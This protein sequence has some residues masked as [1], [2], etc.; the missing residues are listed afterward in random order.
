MAQ[1]KIKL[2]AEQGDFNLGVN[3]Q[4]SCQGITGIWG[5][6]GCGKSTLLRVLAGI[7]KAEGEFQWQGQQWLSLPAHKRPVALVFQKAHLFPHLNVKQNL[8]FAWARRNTGKALVTP[9]QVIQRLDLGELLS[10]NPSQLSGGQ[11]QRVAIGRAL[12]HNP[13]LLLLDEP[14]SALDDAARE[15]ILGY[16]EWLKTLDLTIF[17]VSHRPEEMLQLA[18]HLLLLEQGQQMGFGSIEQLTHGEKSPFAHHK[19]CCSMLEVEGGRVPSEAGLHS[20]LVAGQQLWLPGASVPEGVK[21]RL[22]IM[23]RDVAISR[24]PLSQS[25]VVNQLACQLKAVEV[26][27]EYR[28]LL[29]LEIGEQQL[30]ALITRRSCEKLKL[31]PG[32]K[33]YALVKSVALNRAL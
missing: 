17:Y 26:Q 4:Q 8:M 10:L 23:A 20:L 16:F 21:R 32:D 13:Q 1:L 9:E 22:V 14:L 6:S 28:V 2:D 24:Q 30:L 19:H 3:W 12:L 18:D 27:D 7:Q 29:Q 11:T 15:S 31:E 5:P 33:L 25:S